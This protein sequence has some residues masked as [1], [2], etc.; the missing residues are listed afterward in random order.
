MALACKR[1]GT[2]DRYDTGKCRFCARQRARAGY[3]LNAEHKKKVAREWK[4]QNRDKSRVSSRKGG[5]KDWLPGEHEKA[6]VRLQQ[7]VKCDV[8]DSLDPRHARGWNADHNHTT[9]RFRGIVCHPC[10]IAIA[11][12]ERYGLDRGLQIALYLN[13]GKM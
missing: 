10:N 5:R 6:E 11:H 4:Q 12:V 8:C 9:K 3:H 13:K 7:T 1:C 2:N